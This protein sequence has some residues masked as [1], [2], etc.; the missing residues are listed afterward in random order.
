MAQQTLG[1][2]RDINTLYKDIVDTGFFYTKKFYEYK[3]PVFNKYATDC[4]EINISNE[5]LNKRSIDIYNNRYNLLQPMEFEDP[6][7][8]SET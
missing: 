6:Y 3:K 2:T 5:E 7:N 4:V 8:I 1:R